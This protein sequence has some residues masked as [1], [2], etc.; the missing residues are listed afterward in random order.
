[1]GKSGNL[2]N[3][4]STNPF[5][6]FSAAAQQSYYDLNGTSTSS[7]LGFYPSNLGNTATTWEND[8]L[9]DVGVDVS[10][11]HFDFTFDWFKKA[12][13]GLLFPEPLAQT[14]GGATAPD[15]NFGNIQNVGYDLALT[16]HGVVNRD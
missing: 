12:I 11:S 5:N 14:A 7:Q 3:V 4:P 9:T 1:M 8:V 13:N 2:A 6:L 15:I 16:Y 10:V